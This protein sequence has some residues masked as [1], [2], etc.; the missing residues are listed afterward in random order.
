MN[1]FIVIFLFFFLIMGLLLLFRGNFKTQSNAVISSQHGTNC[2]IDLKIADTPKKKARG[3]MYQKSL[4]EHS[5]MIFVFRNPQKIAFWMKNTLIPLDMIIISPDLIVVDI[6]KNL[7]PM[8]ETMITSDALSAFV[9]EVNGGYC[10]RNGV[11]IGD[12]VSLHL[13]R[14][15]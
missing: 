6:K 15:A 8:S 10:E 1:V 3:L 5:G 2:R 14:I 11:A 9:I 7:N 4:P 12:S 13:N